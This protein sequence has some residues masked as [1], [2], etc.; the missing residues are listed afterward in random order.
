ML[1]LNEMMTAAPPLSNNRL[2]P[3]KHHSF[4]KDRFGVVL[5]AGSRYDVCHCPALVP[6]GVR[7]LPF[8]S[9]TMEALHPGHPALN[10]MTIMILC[11]LR[12]K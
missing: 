1:C 4:I 11:T 9:R 3:Y 6:P 10:V 8:L 7:S 12:F 5:R 2:L